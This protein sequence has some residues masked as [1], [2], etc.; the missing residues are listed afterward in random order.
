MAAT[1]VAEEGIE[2]F[3]KVLATL[4]CL[5]SLTFS[6]NC[7]AAQQDIVI[8]YTN[9]IHCAI[10]DN[11]G[12]ARLA[13]YK[14]ELQAACKHVALVDAGDAIQGAPLGKLSNGAAVV[15]VMNSVGYDFAIPGNHE[16]DYGMEIFKQRAAELSCGYYSANLMAA[17]SGE[18]LL[19]THKVLQ[20]ED[21]KVAFIGVTTPE[22]LSSTRPKYFKDTAGNYLYS[23]CEDAS[24]TKLYAQL[25][26][27]V[28]AVRPQVDYVIL[29]AHLGV[30]G[31]RPQWS[32]EAVAANVAGVDVIIDA[33]SHE[34]NPATLAMGKD[35]KHVI[36]TQTGSK[37]QNI[38]QLTI[39]P[40]GKLSTKLISGLTEQEPATLEV[41]AQEKA[42]FAEL[43]QLP[44][45]ET[46]V[47]FGSVLSR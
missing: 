12:M 44:V 19:P 22:T 34:V 15:N 8:L 36:I 32:S 26:K 42:K 13:Q 23:F 21:T 40:E 43:L 46:T 30:E 14:K 18:L 5:L 38:G 1:V 27:V 29:V 33:H 20:F 3:K 45:G 24:G 10:E 28:D 16:F 17:D 39:T 41:I 11:E 25:Q 47:P 31:S 37:L 4:V 35:D 9:D 2:M 7:C 6:V